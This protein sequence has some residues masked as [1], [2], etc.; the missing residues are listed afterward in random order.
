MKSRWN[1]VYWQLGDYISPIPP[2]KGTRISY[3]SKSLENPCVCKNRN[4][5]EKTRLPMVAMDSLVPIPKQWKSWYYHR[6][7]RTK[8]QTPLLQG[9]PSTPVIWPNYT[10]ST[11]LDF[12]EYEGMSFTKPPFGVRSCEVAIIWRTH[13]GSAAVQHAP[14]LVLRRDWAFSGGDFHP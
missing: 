2:I 8:H 1:Q 4:V 14:P 3:W 7:R 13:L 11:N 6:P 12:P 9:G 10:I 5:S